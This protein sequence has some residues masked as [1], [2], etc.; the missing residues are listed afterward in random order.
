MPARCRIFQTV[1]AAIAW[2]RPTSWPWMRRCPHVGLAVDHPNLTVR[3]GQ[4][5]DAVRDAVSGSDAVISAHAVT[6]TWRQ[7]HTTD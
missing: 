7:R 6:Q 5:S 2:P 1:L 4:L 3:P